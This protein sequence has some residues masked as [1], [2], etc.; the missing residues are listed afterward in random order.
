MPGIQYAIPYP[1]RRL[2]RG[3]ARLAG[4]A[5]I[6]LLARVEV[7]GAE[8]YPRGGPLLAVGNHVAAMEV[9]LMVAYAPWQIELLGPGDIPAQGALGMVTRFYGYTPIRREPR[10]TCR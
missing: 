10:S 5:L 4:R 6:P 8:H 3:L 1:R 7:T 9:A 2:Q